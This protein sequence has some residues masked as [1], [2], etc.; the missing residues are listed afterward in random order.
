MMVIKSD[1]SKKQEHLLEELRKCDDELSG[2]EL[3]RL[4]INKGKS[5]GL[6][7]V[8]RNLQILLKQGLIR[9]RHLPTGEVLYTPVDRD[10]HHLTCV[11]CG[12]TSKLEGC[13]V[14][15]IHTPK[16]NPK[17]FQLLFHTL[18]FFGLCQNCYQQDSL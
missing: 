7:T 11:Q 3:H 10:I 1:I 6:T 17:K 8:Y 4:L 12:E 13:P 9:S 15:S 16:K 14:E 18:E 5:M 2:Q